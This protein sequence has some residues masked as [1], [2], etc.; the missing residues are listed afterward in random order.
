[1]HTHT[2]KVLNLYINLFFFFFVFFLFFLTKKPIEAHNINL[3]QVIEKDVIKPPVYQTLGLERDVCF[4][5]HLTVFLLIFFFF[6]FF[7]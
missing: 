3:F 7:D 6:F 5:S 4:S 2:H 1:M